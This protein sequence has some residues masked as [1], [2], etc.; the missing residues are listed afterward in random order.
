MRTTKPCPT[1]G[2]G[3]LIRADA[4]VC[5]ECWRRLPHDMQRAAFFREP[6]AWAAQFYSEAMA[7]LNWLPPLPSHQDARSG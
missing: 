2:C 6:A 1:R 4:V 5:S 3:A 7:Y